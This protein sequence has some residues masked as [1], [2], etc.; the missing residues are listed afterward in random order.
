MQKAGLAV[1]QERSQK[2]LVG[3]KE[4]QRMQIS[5]SECLFPVIVDLTAAVVIVEDYNSVKASIFL[6]WRNAQVD[7]GAALLVDSPGRLSV[8]LLS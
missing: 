8:N 5:L 2:N 1:G 4:C 6:L 3:R 7:P